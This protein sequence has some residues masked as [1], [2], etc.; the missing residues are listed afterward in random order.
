MPARKKAVA[1]KKNPSAHPALKK[2]PKAEEEETVVTKTS[3]WS[4]VKDWVFK[5]VGTLFMDQKN[6]SYTMSLG[7]V[8]LTCLSGFAIYIWVHKGTDVPSGMLTFLMSM[9]GYVLGTKIND[10]VKSALGGRTKKVEKTQHV[11]RTPGGA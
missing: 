3:K 9:A 5:Y 10:T 11:P 7:R 1:R 6:G 4:V 2:P 8:L